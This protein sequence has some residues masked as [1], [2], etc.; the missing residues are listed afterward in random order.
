MNTHGTHYPSDLTDQDWATLAPLLP[1]PATTGRPRRV[2][3]RAVVNAIFYQNRTGCQWRFLPR[4]FPPKST[5]FYYYRRWSQDGTWERALTALREAVRLRTGREP[6]PSAAILDSQTVKAAPGLRPRGY[7][8]GKK[9][10]RPQAAH[11]RGHAGKPPGGAGDRRQRGRRGSRGAAAGLP[12]AD[13][14]PPADVA[15]CR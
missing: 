3:L 14:L 8:G 10:H 13:G 1:A 4:D 7:D 15:L 11:R 12:T 5:V 2:A 9:D 6:T